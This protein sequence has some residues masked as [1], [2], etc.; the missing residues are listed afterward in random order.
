MSQQAQAVVQAQQK[1]SAVSPPKSNILQHAAVISPLT[2]VH[3]GT[4]QRCTGGVECDEC[5]QKREG[6]IQRAAVNSASTN[7]VPPIVHD[8]LSSSGQ[9]LG[10]GTRAIVE[11]RFGHDFSGVRVHTDSRAA[12]SARA[13][14]AL[15]YTGGRDGVFW[16]GQDEP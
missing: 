10:A 14:T 4:L 2:P 5:R 6:M 12:E 15:A 8:V 16:A 9:P 3:S 13:V 11:P 1:I 7:A